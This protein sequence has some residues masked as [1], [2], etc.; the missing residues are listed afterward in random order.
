M[1]R[2][3]GRHAA[4]AGIVTT[5]SGP[6]RHSHRKAEPSERVVIT[7]RAR[8]AVTFNTRQRTVT[9]DRRFLDAV[10]AVYIDGRMATACEGVEGRLLELVATQLRARRGRNAGLPRWDVVNIK[11]A[12]LYLADTSKITLPDFGRAAAVELALV[13]R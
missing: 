13:G 1:S 3:P 8:R 4:T 10:R 11:T 9:I 5:A 7:P 6:A 2:R 12:L